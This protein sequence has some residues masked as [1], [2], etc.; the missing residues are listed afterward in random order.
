MPTV[1]Y[2]DVVILYL[3]FDFCLLLVGGKE[4]QRNKMFGDPKFV[5][6]VLLQ[7]AV[8]GDMSS[9]GCISSH[10]VSGFVFSSS[11]LFNVILGFSNCSA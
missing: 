11:S 3:C 10:A 9:F 8:M 7:S 4:V 2:T 5:R 1:T 6:V